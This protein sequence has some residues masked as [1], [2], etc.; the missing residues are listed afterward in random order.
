MDWTAVAG[1]RV[2]LRI[3]DRQNN[4]NRQSIMGLGS[5]DTSACKVSGCK[6]GYLL[7]H[8]R[9]RFFFPPYLEGMWGA[10]WRSG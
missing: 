3:R 1:S 2:K 5:R 9:L 6:R 4:F 7:R 10:R 8:A